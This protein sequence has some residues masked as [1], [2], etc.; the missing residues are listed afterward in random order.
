MSEDIVTDDSTS[1]MGAVLQQCVKNAWQSLVF[2][3]KKLNLVQQKNSAHDHELLAIYEAV[4]H[5][6]HMME[7]PLHLH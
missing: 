5:F 3:P 4:K 1:T 7:A 6:C 2:F